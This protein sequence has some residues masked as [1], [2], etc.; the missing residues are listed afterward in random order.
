MIAEVF[1]IHGDDIG[2]IPLHQ[3]AVGR[4]MKKNIEVVQLADN[5]NQ[6]KWTVVKPAP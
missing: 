2:H 4:G 3:Q 5:I 1:K 6:L